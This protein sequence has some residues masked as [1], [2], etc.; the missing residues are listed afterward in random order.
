MKP[1]CK[2]EKEKQTII[3]LLLTNFQHC[4]YSNTV[5][6]SNREVAEKT[7]ENTD[8][9]KEEYSKCSSI[10]NINSNNNN[11]ILSKEVNNVRLNKSK[12]NLSDSFNLNS[13]KSFEKLITVDKKASHDDKNAQE[14]TEP[15]IKDTD[16]IYNTDDLVN[17]TTSQSLV[18]S[19]LKE[20]NHAEEKKQKENVFIIGDSMVKNVH[21]FKLTGMVDHN[22]S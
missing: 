6:I 11:T 19:A 14:T 15:G 17:S 4:S 2:K 16:Q 20:K 13:S 18:S 10:N 7:A 9:P 5:A 22:A 12:E 21:A 8:T 1:L 3:E